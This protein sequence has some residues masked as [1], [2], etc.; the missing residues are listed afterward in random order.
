MEPV[1][2][3]RAIFFTAL[4]SQMTYGRVGLAPDEHSRTAGDDGAP[5]RGDV[6]QAYGGSATYRHSNGTLNDRVGWADARGQVPDHRSGKAADEDGGT[7]GAD[8]GATHVRNWRSAWG[9]H[10]ADV[11]IGDASG[12]WQ[13]K[14][15]VSFS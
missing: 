10:R 7:S 1:E 8:D 2:P 4:F 3:R 15:S 9:D 11:H 12:W 14:N 13:E 5:V 6:A